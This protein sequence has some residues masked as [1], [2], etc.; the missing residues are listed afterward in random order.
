MDKIDLPELVKPALICAC[1]SGKPLS[2]KLQ[3]NEKGILI[4]LVWKAA[5]IPGCS[6]PSARVCSNWKSKKSTTDTGSDNCRAASFSGKLESRN[7]S[8]KRKVAPSCAR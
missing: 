5:P 6:V 7:S 1:N 8:V 3:E 4:Q 2:W